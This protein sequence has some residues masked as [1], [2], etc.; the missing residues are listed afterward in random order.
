MLNE[1]INEYYAQKLSNNSSE[2]DGNWVILDDDDPDALQIN[3]IEDIYSLV[4]FGVESDKDILKLCL[5]E[6][7]TE[8]NVNLVIFL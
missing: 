1:Y 2:K 3:E 8:N 5:D 6:T 7:K 4:E